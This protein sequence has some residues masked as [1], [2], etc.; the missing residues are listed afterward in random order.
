MTRVSCIEIMV[1]I[2]IN[3]IRTGLFSLQLAARGGFG[4]PFNDFK[5]GDDTATKLTQN[6]VL[7]ILNI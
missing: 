2:A 4:G 7:I 6:T 1:S 5:I 3:P